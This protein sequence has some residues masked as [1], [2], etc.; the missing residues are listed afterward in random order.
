MIER[1]LN[2][3]LL[4]KVEP[5]V[6]GLEPTTS[7]ELPVAVLYQL[8]YCDKT[9][10]RTKFSWMSLESFFPSG[11]GNFMLVRSSPIGLLNF[12][13]LKYVVIIHSTQ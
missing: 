9:I 1:E 4:K 10:L 13:L 3:Q 6:V 12:C 7:I 5:Q 2:R 11:T 8:S